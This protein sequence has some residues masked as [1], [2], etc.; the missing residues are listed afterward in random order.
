MVTLVGELRAAV[1]SY[2]G[3]HL[4]IIDNGHSVSLTAFLPLPAGD[5]IKTSIRV[6]FE[7]LGQGFDRESCVVFYAATLGAFVDLA[8]GFAY[9]LEKPTTT[10]SHPAKS[11]DSS[12]CD[13]Q[14]SRDQG[15]SHSQHGLD[16]CDGHR[17]IVLDADLPPPTTM[18]G[19]IG[20]DE[21]SMVDRAV[22]ILIDHG[23]KPDHAQAT[24][25]RHAAAAGVEPH[26]YAARLLRR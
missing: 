12:D 17:P 9:A 21:R 26:I 15:D 22:A 5:S 20:L 24:L 3:L 8:A 16:R 1:P 7:A 13:G 14:Y 23:H 11:A 6:G 10:P 4:T 2:R 18:S 19:L 25:C